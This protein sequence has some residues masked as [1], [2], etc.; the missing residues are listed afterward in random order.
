MRS[1]HVWL[2]MGWVGVM[3]LALAGHLMP[4]A[5][6][7]LRSA[8]AINSN[9]LKAES[10]VPPS[11]LQATWVGK[12]V[13]LT[14]NAGANGDRYI[15]LGAVSQT[16][17]CATAAWKQIGR[18]SG[19]TT[20]IYVDAKRTLPKGRWY[21]YMVQ[22]AMRN[23]TSSP[24]PTT[25]IQAKIAVTATPTPTWTTTPTRTATLVATAPALTTPAPIH[26]PAPTQKPT[27][28]LTP[29]LALTNT[30]TLTPTPTRKPTNTAT[31]M[32]TVTRTPT[33]SPTLTASPTPSQTPLR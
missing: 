18:V 12:N 2:W 19:I 20:T 1:R 7:T 29:T 33:V 17:N 15:V 22:T 28:T 32:P 6:A 14:W 3:V 31:P 8:A 9:S 16:S 30:S 26:T 4:S 21:C 23:W 10:L 5:T 25:A 24:N 11:K 27:N 13:V